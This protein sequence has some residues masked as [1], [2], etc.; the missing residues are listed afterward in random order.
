MPIFIVSVLLQIAL[1]LHIVKTGRNTTWIWIVVMLPLAGSIA[2]LIVEV[3]PGLSGSRTGRKAAR[4]LDQAL[5]PERELKDATHAYSLSESIENTSRL[6]H[7][8]YAK[9]FYEEAKPLYEKCLKGPHQHD[10]YLMLGLANTEF[11]LEHYPHVKTLLDQL[12]E[13]NPDFKN[14]DAHLLYARTLEALGDTEK[15]LHEYQA[16][17]GYYPGAEASYRYAKLIQSQG[18]HAQAQLL[19]DEILL[20]AKNSGAHYR[21]L[22]REW[23]KKARQRGL[24]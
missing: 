16:L 3:L 2:Y 23:I 24:A 19:F 21:E 18:N 5:N 11:Q 22:H 7:A 15:A 1:V 17:H 13:H 12:I 14:A 10:P 8:L 20:K 9:G 6:A 4:K